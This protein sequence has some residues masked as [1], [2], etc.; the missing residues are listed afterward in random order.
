[1]NIFGLHAAKQAFTKIARYENIYEVPSILDDNIVIWRWEK[2]IN[3]ELLSGFTFRIEFPK[4]FPLYWPKIYLEEESREKL[5]W[6]PHVGNAGNICL[7][8]NHTSPTLSESPENIVA[9]AMQKAVQTIRLYSK[10]I[11]ED[12]QDEYIAYWELNYDKQD[13]RA[14]LAWGDFE[15][16]KF[17]SVNILQLDKNISFYHFIGV[18]PADTFAF[19]NYLE[20]TRNKIKEN[21]KAFYIGELPYFNNPP[22]SLKNSDIHRIIIKEKLADNSYFSNYFYRTPLPIILFTKDIKGKKVHLGWVHTHGF[23][24]H[25]NGFRNNFSQ[26]LFQLSCSQKNDSVIRLSFEHLSLKRLHTRSAGMD[27]EASPSFLLAGVGSIGS[28]LVHF[29]NGYNPFWTLVDKDM[30][31]IENIGRHYLGLEYADD[32]KVNSMKKF[33]IKKNPMLAV[34]TFQSDILDVLE[35][36]LDDINNNDYI[37]SC[38]AENN[39]ES[40][41]GELLHQGSITVPVFF[42]WV[43]PYLAGGHCLFIPPRSKYFSDFFVEGIYHQNVITQDNYEKRELLLELKEAGCQSLYTPYAQAEVLLFL[44]ALFPWIDKIFKGQV[45]STQEFTWIG[46]IEYLKSKGINISSD[47]NG[48]TMGDVIRKSYE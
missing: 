1:M 48:Y 41:L 33:L 43:E 5:G 8:D 37:F 4:Y 44:A 40:Y 22:F 12:Y 2:D 6:I 29:L 23:K 11:Q 30:L 28:N 25:V 18:P 17:S 38:L 15:I 26:R 14:V 32:S 20:L 9:N 31:E 19:N 27:T 16:K 42:I 39:V 45:S 35:K 10:P 34:K 36:H 46:N 21:F 3:N 7:F 13:I 24:R 47:F